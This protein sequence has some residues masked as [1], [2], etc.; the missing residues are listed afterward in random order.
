MEID[1][2]ISDEVD[3][4]SRKELGSFLSKYN[5]EALQDFEKGKMLEIVARDK[6]GE[7]IGGVYAYSRWTWMYV[8][9]LIVREDQRGNGLGR[10]LMR[11]CEI[12]CEKREIKRIRLNTFEFQAPDFYKKLGFKVAAIEE[13]FPPGHRTYY[14]QKYL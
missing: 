8:D 3:K 11:L 12:E 13:D 6:S 7:I 5:T 2:K 4:D 1:Y 14:M 9:W 10:E